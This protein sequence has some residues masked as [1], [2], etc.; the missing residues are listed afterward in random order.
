MRALSPRRTG[1][2]QLEL[3]RSMPGDIAPRDAQDLMSWPF[4]SLAKQADGAHC[5]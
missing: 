5:V 1:D 2:T 4:F 3:F